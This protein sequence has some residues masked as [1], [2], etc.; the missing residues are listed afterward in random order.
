MRFLDLPLEVYAPAISFVLTF[1][2]PIGFINFYP[3]QLFLSKGATS[4]FAYLTPLIGIASFIFSYSLWKLGV[5]NY[6]S[7]GS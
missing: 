1:I 3:A 6:S 2:I 5:K 4:Y 7:T